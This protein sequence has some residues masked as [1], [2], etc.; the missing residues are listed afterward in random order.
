LA[1]ANPCLLLILGLLAKFWPNTDY[2]ANKPKIKS[3]QGFAWAKIKMLQHHQDFL[4]LY[5]QDGQIKSYMPTHYPILDR[6][7]ILEDLA[8]MQ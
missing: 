8:G 7:K 4:F 6:E 2:V 3:R 1:Q 5:W